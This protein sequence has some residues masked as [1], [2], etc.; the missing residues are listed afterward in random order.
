MTLQRKKEEAPRRRVKVIKLD[1]VSC[2]NCSGNDITKD[3]VCRV[4]LMVKSRLD[5]PL[6]TSRKILK[7]F[8]VFF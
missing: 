1:D 4:A 7:A 5:W 6:T 2:S 8:E 3:E